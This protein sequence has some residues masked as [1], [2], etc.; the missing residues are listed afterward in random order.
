LR[1]LLACATSASFPTS[2]GHATGRLLVAT[3]WIPNEIWTAKIMYSYGPKYQSGWWLT[4]PSE[5]Y[6]FISRDDDIPN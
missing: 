5:K 2:G 4:Y 1:P 6:D 3:K